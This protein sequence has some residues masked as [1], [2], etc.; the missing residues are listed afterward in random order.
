VKLAVEPARVPIL[1][2]LAPGT[3]MPAWISHGEGRLQASDDE[4]RRLAREGH[5][6]FTYCDAGG[7][8]IP[9][10]QGSALDCA[11]LTNA[12]G[13]AL[14][15]MPHPERDAWTFMQRD[16]AVKAAA[17]GDAQAMLAPAGGIAFFAAFAR[18]LGA[19]AAR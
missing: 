8:A 7:S 5:V 9:A 2:G 14:A 3:V 12:A 18:A 6:A 11:A 10:P 13:T 15:I 17:R 16:G 4:L 1:A 19:G